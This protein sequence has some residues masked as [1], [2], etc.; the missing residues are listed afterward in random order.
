MGQLISR[1]AK[2]SASLLVWYQRWWIIQDRDRK[3]TGE[4][5]KTEIWIEIGDIYIREI[6]ER[7]SGE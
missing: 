4:R 6:M 3:E 5:W 2:F 1:R 7:K